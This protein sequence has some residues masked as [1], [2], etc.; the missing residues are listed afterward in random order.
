MGAVL[1]SQDVR[2]MLSV[3][4]R[5]II[6]STIIFFFAAGEFQP[7]SAVMSADA[8]VV[9]S[10]DATPQEVRLGRRGIEEI[11]SHWRV[12][13]DPALQARVETIV[14]RLEPFMSR[15]LLY[16][17]RIVDQE[18]VNAFSLSGGTMYVTTGILDFV[19][20][21]LELAGVI[22]H[23]MVHAD[24][25]HVMIQ[26][27]RN[28]RMTLLTLAA[29]ILSRGEGAAIIAASALQVAVMGAYSIDL[30]MEAD[31][32]GIDALAGAGYNPVGMITLQ[33]RL[34]E[35]R[36]KRAHID[37]G[38]Y[39][40]HPEIDERIAAA[41]KYME[42][43]S[44]PVNRK[45]SLGLLRPRVE[46]E[47][48]SGDLTLTI[49]GAVVWRGPDSAPTKKLFDRVASELWNTLQLE[50]APY[51][52]RAEGVWPDE[53]LFIMGRT[54]VVGRELPEDVAPLSFLRE[55]IQLAV[56]AARRSHPMADYFM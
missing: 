2:V 46:Y 33:E 44:I 19:K 10:S 24:R 50:T 30:E 53:S 21:D 26:T 28:D 55:G 15:K 40:T 14:T 5:S 29:A 1:L 42:E 6:L 54:V 4:L 13:K 45:H 12:I 18:M 20:T 22:A 9:V 11:E 35:E 32:R 34:K 48:V 39:Q 27:A 7:A 41:I 49:D 51:D 56:T 16:D 36:L 37:P 52:I 17:V 43:H 47:A 8:A 3:K 38:I 23:E 31:S 25:K